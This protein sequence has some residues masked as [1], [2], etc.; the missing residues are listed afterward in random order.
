MIEPVKPNN[1]PGTLIPFGPSG[2]SIAPF[3]IGI[4]IAVILFIIFIGVK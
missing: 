3:L 2:S 4:L 1:P